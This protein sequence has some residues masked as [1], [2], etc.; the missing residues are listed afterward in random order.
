[1]VGIG[2]AIGLWLLLPSVVPGD[3]VL[4]PVDEEA[5]FGSDLVRRAERFERLLLVLWLC[6]QAAL[7]LVLWAYAKRGAAFARESAAGPLGTGMLLGML[8]LGLVWLAQLPFGLVALWWE[9]RYDVSEVGYLESLLDD[10]L[11]LGGTFTAIC[12]ALLIVMGLA[13]WLG[14][15]WWIPG[16]A[17]FVGIAALFTFGAPYL[18]TGLEPLDDP[19]LQ[20]AGERYQAQQ[21]VGDIPMRVETVSGDTSQA[22]AYAFGIGPS[23]KI[24]LWDTLL[25]GRFSDG[26]ERVV[27]AHEI[28]HHSSRHLVKGLG[29]F[30]LFALPGA[31]ILMRL[32]RGRGGMGE[33]AAVPLALLVVAVLQLVAAPA[34]NAIS[35]RMESEADWK[36]LQSTRDPASARALFVSF[37]ETSLGDPDPP[38]WSEL[39]LGT[40]PTLADRVA[41]ANAWKEREPAR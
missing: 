40:H 23:R 38:E 2:W 34:Q 37:A 36:A 8:G 28:G 5:V 22:N 14:E 11:T 27:L 9:R 19:A 33:P 1:M 29:W 10:W 41:M 6:A 39:L 16:A 24:V 21:G 12:L 25:D 26:A 4:S 7:L 32:T 20:A 15:W 18:S 30:A 35:R 3:L 13:R 17:V 31:W